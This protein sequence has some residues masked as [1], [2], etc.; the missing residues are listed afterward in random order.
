MYIAGILSQVHHKVDSVHADLHKR[1]RDW[2][3]SNGEQA[4]RRW[5]FHQGDPHGG[6]RDQ[7]GDDHLGG[8]G[9]HDD[10]DDHGSGGDHDDEDDHGGGGDHDDEDDYGGHFQEDE[11]A[12]RTFAVYCGLALHHA[13]LYDKIRR[14]EQKYKV[15]QYDGDGGGDDHDHDGGS[16]GDDGDG[17]SN[18]DGTDLCEILVPNIR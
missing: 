17:G 5:C 9:D 18:G 14:S 11:D 6:G 13:K 1:N 2:S 16:D 15:S 3:C 4:T 8:G 7:D 12:F 10:E